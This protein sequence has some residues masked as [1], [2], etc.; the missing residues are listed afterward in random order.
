[1]KTTEAMKARGPVFVAQYDFVF[2]AGAESVNPYTVGTQQH[3]TYMEQIEKLT[4]EQGE[5]K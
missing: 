1:M 4:R 2:G 5:K 3:T